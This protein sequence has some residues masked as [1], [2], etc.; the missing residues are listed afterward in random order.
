M[1]KVRYQ[2]GDPSF[3]SDDL[4][5][6]GMGVQ[7]SM[8]PSVIDRPNGFPGQFLLMLFYQESELLV[9]SRAQRFPPLS[10]IVWRPGRP[11]RY[12]WLKGAW[13]HSWLVCDGRLAS[14]LL[15]ESGLEMERPAPLNDPSLFEAH[16]LAIDQEACGRL[17]PDEVIVRNLFQNM[18]REIARA[19]KGVREEARIP[20]AFIDVKCHI[21][22]HLGRKLSLSSLAKISGLS[23]PRFCAEFKRLFGFPAIDY[24][25]RRRMHEAMAL[26]RDRNMRIREVSQALG[27]SDL[28]YFSRHF[29]R[30]F[31]ASPREMRRKL[32]EPLESCCCPDGF[33]PGGELE[34]RPAKR[35]S[36]RG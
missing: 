35:S 26:L 28:Y 17:V 13:K 19:A 12:G 1:R 16:L 4:R 14:R 25:I 15:K 3:A 6:F 7:E 5:I 33:R 20:Q 36:R 9:D 31:G 32:L 27:Y 23:V 2:S 34:G 22:S 21:D 18:L 30:H 29:K 10:F 24:A 8:E 11:Q